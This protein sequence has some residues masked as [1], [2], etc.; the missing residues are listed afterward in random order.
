ML[1]LDAVRDPHGFFARLREHDPV[2]WS[3]RHRGYIL[4]S[5][6]Q[7]SSAFR[8]QALSAAAPMKGFRKRLGEER[9]Q[10]MARALALLDGWMLMNDPP[11][12][13]RLREPVRR[14]FGPQVA[15][16]SIPK[17]EAQVDRLL[18]GL[19]DGDDLVE[20]F[21]HP[22]PAMVIC[23]LLGV[24]DEDRAFL[25]EWT[26]DFAKLIYGASSKDEGY[27]EI[28][29]RAGNEFHEKLTPLI[30]KR[31][32]DPDDTLLSRLIETS[33]DEEW[34]EA[35]LLGACSM[36]L[37]AGHDTTAIFIASAA[38]VLMRGGDAR[39]RFLE[40]PGIA[41]SAIEELLRV[42]GPSKTF[43]R[44]AL[45]SHERGGHVIEAG[46]PL[47]LA[48]LGAN[49]DPD[50]FTDPETLDLARDPN[51]HIGFGGGIHFCA[52]ATL[53]RTEAKIA[54][55][56]LFERF[57]DMSLASESVTWNR[58]VIDRSLTALPV[59]FS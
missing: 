6:D 14:S 10:A 47:W 12:H 29:S 50:I 26:K 22:L 5:H 58:A 42:E 51:P 46:A 3:E 21:A 36:L 28:V 13:T 32:A 56:R 37:F 1:A 20:A 43:P 54:L 53:A 57:P 39:R 15:R 19:Q 34:T 18:D 4:T 23:D 8:D 7:V 11:E 9:R 17:I 45:E 59:R 25:G 52:G 48:V 30:R 2:F 24:E 49:H 27:V 35:E 55:R 38:H 41:D 31:I 40:D 16:A 33:R 44:V